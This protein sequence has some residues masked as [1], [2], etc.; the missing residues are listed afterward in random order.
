[1]AI[2]LGITAVVLLDAGDDLPAA[3]AQLEARLPA[4]S[5][6]PV[7]PA[8]P[9]DPG[10]AVRLRAR[11]EVRRVRARLRRIPWLPRTRVVDLGRR[12]RWIPFL[13]TWLRLPAT[14]DDGVR[15]G[16]IRAAF[17]H[18]RGPVA[19]QN[20]IFLAALAL[21]LDVA[22]P[23]L[24]GLC[25]GG[26]AA[27]AEDAEVALAFSGDASARAAFER[28]ALTP[29]P[30]EARRVMDAREA[31]ETL[32]AR[33]DEAAREIL[34]SYR[35]VEA[36]L[37]EPYFK[38]MALDVSHYEQRGNDFQAMVGWT[39]GAPMSPRER[40]RLV[41]AWMARYP[42]HPGSDDLA[43]RLG[44]MYAV[45]GDAVEAARWFG[46]AAVLPDQDVAWHAARNLAGLCEVDLSPEQVLRL[47]DDE[48]AATPN[49]RFLQYVWLRRLA[50]E[51]GFDV[52]LRAAGDLAHREPDGEIAAAWAG[53]WRVAPP[54]GLDSGRVPL[55]ADDPLRRRD[56]GTIAWP[57]PINP[58]APAD[59]HGGIYTGR[60]P[61]P[62]TRLH[63]SPEP[64]VL[65]RGKLV[66]QFRAWE[67]LAELEVRA[68]G[69]RG[70][71]RADL[72]YKQAAICYHDR[73]VLYPVYGR[74]TSTFSGTLSS[75]L[76]DFDR[77]PEARQAA[78]RARARFER[79]SLS[80]LRALDLFRQ[81][82]RETPD[83][84][85]LDEVVFSEG[86]L[87]KRLV[88]YRPNSACTDAAREAVATFDRLVRDFPDS[89][90]AGDARAAA[91]WWRRARPRL[92]GER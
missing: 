67:T 75:H 5:S 45:R 4:P 52:A 77:A 6:P 71:A 42:G 2:G 78:A 12:A 39:N 51:R 25:A 82:E 89:P 9:R 88:D 24:Q 91:A 87:F 79:T 73:D 69:A 86:M 10:L 81:I 22:R 59:G 11:K 38:M 74:H 84:P 21:P 50:A 14:E 7:Q 47:S 37:R 57:R 83:W 64:I 68:A 60:G 35:A 17:A 72:L 19:R 36:L 40:T 70:Y 43:A 62:E 61:A 53:R 15:L 63:P 29:A 65:D 92:L 33:D 28:R 54:A 66:R 1:L 26:D 16:R 76:D 58:R 55:P 48:G 30:V 80:Y 90:L 49:R 23:W 44:W 27:D 31:H 18:A 34:R 56:P 8:P 41:E 3:P 13:E 20:L 32:A 46:R 85:A